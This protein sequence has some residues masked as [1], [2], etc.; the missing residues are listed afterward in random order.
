MGKGTGKKG[1]LHQVITKSLSLFKSRKTIVF[2]SPHKFH[3]AH[4]ELVINK[5]IQ[6]YKKD[7]KIIVI[8]AEPIKKQY[9]DVTYL[10]QITQ[11]SFWQKIDLFVTTE[12]YRELP[13]W[14]TTK[15]VFFGH[16]IG[17]K[18]NYQ[19]QE[20]L[21]PF[22]FIFTP[23]LPFYTLQKEL[24]P[25]ENIFKVGLPILDNVT[26]D[27]A[28]LTTNFSLNPKLPTLVYAP[29][30]CS[31]TELIADLPQAFKLLNELENFNVIVSPHPLLFEPSR[32]G[33]LDFF[34]DDKQ[35][36]NLCFNLPETGISTLEI[37]AYVD[38]V[39]SDISSIS[40]E[41][42]A[43]KKIVLIENNKAMFD[44]FGALEVFEEL[45]HSC[46][47]V[48]WES[49]NINDLL[50]CYTYDNYQQSRKVYIENY[51][52]N[53]GKATDVFIEKLNEIMSKEP[54]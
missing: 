30:W 47:I 2:D 43:L 18:L 12:F 44:K 26:T 54:Y 27:I 8:C 17:P 3:F 40:F 5:L 50:N 10:T 49:C 51:L 46:Q 28:Q 52:F 9:N 15:T 23:A 7:Y 13:F 31:Y 22:D 34:H 39:I 38:V 6:S 11:L 53:N 33:G 14:L 29:S 32:C 20:L 42:L 41:A 21:A 4:V 24:F 45:S 19:T 35:Y 36:E 25:E 16:G 48:D 1:F 37:V